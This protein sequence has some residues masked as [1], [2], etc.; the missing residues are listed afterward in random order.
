MAIFM[1]GA[2]HP[3]FSALLD[4]QVQ[5]IIPMAVLISLFLIVLIMRHGNTSLVQTLWRATPGWMVFGLFLTNAIVLIGELAIFTLV[6][7]TDTNQHSLPSEH[8]PLLTM[9]LGSIGFW[10]NALTRYAR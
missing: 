8:I 5:S 2:A 3:T 10:L 6:I 4:A 7:I 1:G 9:F